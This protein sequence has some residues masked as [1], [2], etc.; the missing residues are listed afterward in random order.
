[1]VKSYEKLGFVGGQPSN[2]GIAS[3]E[4]MAGTSWSGAGGNGEVRSTNKL[5]D[6]YPNF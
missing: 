3:C 4:K 2:M 1:M 6:D 5:A